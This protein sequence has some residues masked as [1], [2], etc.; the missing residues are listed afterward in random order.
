MDKEA[1]NEL[2]EIIKSGHDFAVE[3]MPHVA[4][5]IIF[6]EKFEH[7]VWFTVAVL[8]LV[9][10]TYLWKIVISKFQKWDTEPFC[11]SCFFLVLVTAF[12]ILG[13]VL[14]TSALIKVWCAPRLVI[15]DYLGNLL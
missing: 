2:M 4:Q 10:L 14:E 11:F 1:I 7:S 13:L 8:V 9:G 5:E 3:Q 15:L 12:F 6:Y